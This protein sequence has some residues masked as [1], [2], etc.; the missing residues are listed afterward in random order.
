M[1]AFEISLAAIVLV[2]GMSAALSEPS[3]VGSDSPANSGDGSL[4]KRAPTANGETAGDDIRT[5]SRALRGDDSMNTQTPPMSNPPNK[6]PSSPT[7]PTGYPLV[8]PQIE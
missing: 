7:S 3:G 4:T 2:I 5:G 8:P 1:K 6:R